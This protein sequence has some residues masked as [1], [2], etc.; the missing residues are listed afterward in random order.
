M[1]VASSYGYEVV[2]DL[3]TG[4]VT[5]RPVDRTRTLSE[6]DDVERRMKEAFGS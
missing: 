6:A 3:N 4:T 1:A 5:A 2:F